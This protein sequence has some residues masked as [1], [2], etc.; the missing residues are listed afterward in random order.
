MR[1]AGA[2]ASASNDTNTTEQSGVETEY[3]R[4]SGD[5][6]EEEDEELDSGTDST[7]LPLPLGLLSD[8][9]MMPLLPSSSRSRSRSGGV[10]RNGEG[11]TQTAG[12]KKDRR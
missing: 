10:K 6:E 1:V 8:P 5:T 3:R 4:S 12:R 11:P 2:S 9:G 7:L